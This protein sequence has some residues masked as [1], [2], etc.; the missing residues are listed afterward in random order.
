M[1]APPLGGT[2]YQFAGLNAVGALAASVLALDL[3][4]RLLIIEKCSAAE[5]NPRAVDSPPDHQRTSQFA[6]SEERTPLLANGGNFNGLTITPRQ[7][8]LF[9]KVPLLYCLGTPSMIV[10]LAVVFSEAVFFSAFDATVPLHAHELFGFNALKSGL[11]MMPIGIM[12]VL[13]GPLA[14]WAVDRVGPKPLAVGGFSFAAVGMPLLAIPTSGTSSIHLALYVGSLSLCGVALAML[15]TPAMVESLLLVERFRK[16]NP[17]LFDNKGP[18]AQHNAIVYT[19]FSLG[20]ST[21]PVISGMLKSFCGYANMTIFM[22]GVAALMAIISLIWLGGPIKKR[23][24]D[25]VLPNA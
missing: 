16:A 21:G 8:Y 13:V 22:G 20:M 23:S 1:F 17:G 3:I 7:S 19:F 4:L 5:F 15:D 10:S 11:M 24:A 9:Q 2:I 6:S 25:N 14:G 12:T 18:Y